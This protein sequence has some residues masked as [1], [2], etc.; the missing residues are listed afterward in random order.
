MTQVAV[1]LKSQETA[2]VTPRSAGNLKI[3]GDDDCK[4]MKEG[5][6]KT[7]DCP[8]YIAAA[9]G[10]GW[11]G[12]NT[13][14]DDLKVKVNPGNDMGGCNPEVSSNGKGNPKE[15]GRPQDQGLQQMQV[16][17]GTQPQDQEFPHARSGH[18]GQRKSGNKHKRQ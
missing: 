10:R 15:Q 18:G 12:K 3:K 13:S 11:P 14:D 17:K 9:A 1:T 5:N 7:K 8:M 2:N 16:H 4:G 6:P